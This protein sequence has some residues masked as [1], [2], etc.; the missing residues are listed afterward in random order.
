LIYRL[1]ETQKDIKNYFETG[2]FRNK[3]IF[4][5][6]YQDYMNRIANDWTE[7]RKL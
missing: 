6:T 3:D 7:H 4:N 1:T 5:E 2:K